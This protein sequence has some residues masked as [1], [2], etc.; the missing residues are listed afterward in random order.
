[1]DKTTK[2]ISTTAI[3]A[4]SVASVALA[5]GV[6][7]IA[8]IETQKVEATVVINNT[9]VTLS[10]IKKVTIPNQYFTGSV[11]GDWYFE[12][13]VVPNAGFVFGNAN[14]NF[15][16]FN[17][18]GITFPTTKNLLIPIGSSININENQIIANSDGIDISSGALKLPTVF[19]TPSS[20]NNYQQITFTTSFSGPIVGTSTFR[21]TRIGNKIFMDGDEFLTNSTADAT[22]ISSTSPLPLQFRPAFNR[23]VPIFGSNADVTNFIVVTLNILTSGF[24]LFSGINN[25]LWVSPRANTGWASF[26][27]FWGSV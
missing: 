4:I 3:I 18:D 20:L 6:T 13:T 27:T 19:G 7:A 8:L 11:V 21:I 12:N 26:D 22:Y 23:Q 5:I 1:M 17:L 14:E 9:T 2:T 10:E 16:T 15:V 25:E 24:I